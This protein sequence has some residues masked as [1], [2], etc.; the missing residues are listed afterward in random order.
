MPR[1]S[2]R[3]YQI[4]AITA[5]QDAWRRGKRALVAIATGGGKTTVLAE[6][7]RQ[8]IDPDLQRAVVLG[9]TKEIVEQCYA[10]IDN[11]F[12]QSLQGNFYS[13]GNTLF[14]RG[15]G[16][17]MA[18]SDESDAR[19]IVATRQSLSPSRTKRLLLSG[20]VDLLVVDEAHHALDDNT[21][22]RIM[23][24]LLAENPLLKVVG[25]TATPART[26]RKALGTIFD[27]IVYEWLI[28]DGV[29]SGNLVPVQRVKVATAIDLSGVKTQ[30]GDYNAAQMLSIL[31]ATNW[32][33]LAVK[34]YAKHIGDRPCLAFMPSV[35]MSKELATGLQTAGFSAAHV[36][37]ETPKPEREA[38]L[39]AYSKGDIRCV[40]NMAVLTEGFDAPFT[41]AILLGRPTRSKT[42]FTQIVGRGLRP[43]DG[44]T[45]CLLLDLTVTDTKQLDIGTLFGKIIKC[46]GCKR[47]FMAGMAVCPNC[48]LKPINEWVPDK[49]DDSVRELPVGWFEGDGIATVYAEMMFNAVRDS[50]MS[51]YVDTR[52]VMTVGI[53]SEYGTMVVIP[54]KEDDCWALHVLPSGRYA[55][56][57]QITNGKLAE[58]LAVAE[59]YIRN[60]P[61]I[62]RLATKNA[63]WKGAKA[64]ESQLG[65]LKKLGYE[66]TESLSKGQAAELITHEFALERLEALWVR[67]NFNANT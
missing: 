42:L 5:V 8:H 14:T 33:E 34:A 27:E 24:D 6:L 9:H 58:V 25:F 40:S 17:V 66:A 60:R 28:P 39:K 22:G 47:E 21:Y 11:Q 53:G 2:L 30:A 64:S 3:P 67:G 57:E 29:A 20:K 52:G 43:S 13:T 61:S 41:G 46:K 16:M 12:E 35:A 56:P 48:G 49:K 44:K 31:G 37:G 45:D 63:L 15:L 10:R 18:E 51:W 38:I 59:R 50:E 1:Q 62:E 26:D 7:I 55:H 65:L 19:V 36:D 32:V 54:S 23:R 4:E